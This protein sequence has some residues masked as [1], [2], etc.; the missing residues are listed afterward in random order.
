MVA[1]VVLLA[2]AP[3][4][5]VFAGLI[6]ATRRERLL[7]SRGRPTHGYISDMGFS[8]APAEGGDT[9]YWAKV[10]YDQDGVSTTAKV[11]ISQWEH[12]SHRIGQRVLLTYVPGH[13]SIVGLIPDRGA[14]PPWVRASLN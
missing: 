2:A 10:R 1:V 4:A 11:P 13:P 12:L 6:I 8:M 14:P 5:A 9:T 7:K 3:I